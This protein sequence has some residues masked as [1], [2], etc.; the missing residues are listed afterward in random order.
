MTFK[1]ISLKIGREVIYKMSISCC[2]TGHRDI[3]VEMVPKIK[4]RLCTEVQKQI[5]EGVRLFSAGGARGFDTLAALTVLECKKRNPKIMLVL[6]YPC[7]DQAKGWK[8]ED[9]VLYEYIEK[10]ADA[11]IYV[12]KNYHNGCMHKRNRFMVDQ[13]DVCICYLTTVTGGTK[14]TVDYCIRKG[15]PIINLAEG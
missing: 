3:P 9:I 7:Q 15:V 2:F 11:C 5:D 1:G 12:S 10:H 13:S 8:E 14:Y 6:C 4:A